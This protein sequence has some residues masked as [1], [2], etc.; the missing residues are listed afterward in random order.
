MTNL[1][2]HGLCISDPINLRKCKSGDHARGASRDSQRL[3]IC[4]LIRR[5]LNRTTD[6][7]IRKGQRRI[8]RHGFG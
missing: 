2:K 3:S 8:L 7:F 4:V 6:A 5:V 1:Q